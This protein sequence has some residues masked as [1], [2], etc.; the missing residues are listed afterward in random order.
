MEKGL[1]TQYEQASKELAAA[2][3]KV[4]ELEIK[5]QEA[6]K[7]KAA[8]TARAEAL[9]QALLEEVDGGDSLLNSGDDS[10]IGSLATLLRIENGWESAIAVANRF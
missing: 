5:S 10:L 7:S 1:D 2:D 4:A 9:Q 8:L 3:T 6:A